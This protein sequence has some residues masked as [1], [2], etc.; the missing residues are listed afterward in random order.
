MNHQ[1]NELLLIEDNLHDAELALRAFQK[2]NLLNHVIH[3]RN[4]RQALDYLLAEGEFSDRHPASLPSLILLDLNLPLVNGF[5]VLKTIKNHPRLKMIPVV[6]L[7]SSKEEADLT[8]AY[9]LWVNSYIVKPVAF[10]KFMEVI[11]NLGTYWLKMNQLPDMKYSY[12]NN[13]SYE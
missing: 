7:T 3:L 8:K 2:N 4:G 9:R 5:E 13:F 10:S 12:T 1:D 6:V 11:N